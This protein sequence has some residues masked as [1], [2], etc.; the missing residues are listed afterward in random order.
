MFFHRYTVEKMHFYPEALLKNEVFVYKHYWK[1]SF[2]SLTPLEILLVFL[3]Y[4]YNCVCVSAHCCKHVFLSQEYG[5]LPAN[6]V[7]FLCTVG[8]CVFCFMSWHTG[9]TMC[10]CFF[11]VWE[12]CTVVFV[13]LHTVR[14]LCFVHI[15]TSVYCT[16]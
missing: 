9:G 3:F 15:H 6:C 11:T 12:S 1:L 8:N 10:L 2:C 5:T 4:E 13:F 14:K 7:C 16:S